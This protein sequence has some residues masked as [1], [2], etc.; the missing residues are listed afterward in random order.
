MQATCE[1]TPNQYLTQEENHQGIC[2]RCGSWVANTDPGAARVRCSR[3]GC[4]T[5]HGV[6][7]ALLLGAVQIRR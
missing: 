4:N 1:L 2:L 5:L 6:E 3:C 7:Q